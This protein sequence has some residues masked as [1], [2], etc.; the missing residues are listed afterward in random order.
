MFA[1]SVDIEEEE[2]SERGPGGEVRGLQLWL[3]SMRRPW[4]R[5]DLGLLEYIPAGSWL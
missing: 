5:E 1:I 4:G 2:L 3:P